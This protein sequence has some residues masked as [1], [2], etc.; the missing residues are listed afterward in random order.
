MTGRVDFAV[1]DR[2]VRQIR[3][4][5]S[6]GKVVL[7]RLPEGRSLIAAS[8]PSLK[9][10][11]RGEERYEVDGEW[12]HVRPGFFL[13]L[14]SGS[15]CVAA[16]SKDTLGLCLTLPAAIDAGGR[17]VFPSIGRSLILPTATMAIA[18]LVAS[19]ARRIADEPAMGQML[20]GELLNHVAAAISGP[21]KDVDSAI[22]RLEARKPATRKAIYQRLEQA[23]AHL[24][25]HCRRPVSLDELAEHSGMS[26]F[27]FARYFTSAFGRSPI[28]YHRN[29]RLDLAAQLFERGDMRVGQVSD[30]LGYSDQVAFTHAFTR[31]FG[32]SPTNWTGRFRASKPA[33]QLRTA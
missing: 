9:L 3:S 1:M 21:M 26:A 28:A 23:R 27:H 33:P 8:A 25:T 17:P 16:V 32:V 6:A 20:A 24:H 29:L 13:Y 5:H 15:D 11:L 4:R 19:T 31:K 2:H 7:S 18:E 12:H 30:F 10:V 22:G 14:D